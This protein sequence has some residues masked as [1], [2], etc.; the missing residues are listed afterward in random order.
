[1]VHSFPNFGGKMGNLLINQF[2]VNDLI[3]MDL[4][5]PRSRCDLRGT[6]CL[7]KLSQSQALGL[8]QP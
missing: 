7:L 1:M 4:P 6:S 8:N 3:G 5:R 2:L